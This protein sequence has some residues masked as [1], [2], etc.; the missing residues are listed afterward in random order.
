MSSRY[1]LNDFELFH[2]HLC[3]C[4]P[5]FLYINRGILTTSISLHQPTLSRDQTENNQKCEKVD[6]KQRTE[7]RRRRA[8]RGPLAGRDKGPEQISR[9]LIEGG[10]SRCLETVVKHWSSWK[11]AAGLALSTAGQN[12]GSTFSMAEWTGRNTAERKR[13]EKNR[14][15]KPLS[16]N[17]RQPQPRRG[18]RVD[19]GSPESADKWLPTLHRSNSTDFQCRVLFVSRNRPAR[20][21]DDRTRPASSFPLAMNYPLSRRLSRVSEGVREAREHS[22]WMS[23]GVRL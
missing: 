3:R 16:F 15:E 22:F 13:S 20:P 2:L 12:R 8:G 14:G 21:F 9:R 1:L 11:G 17:R 19:E 18:C 6:R 5:V 23:T 4:L 7:S 10:S